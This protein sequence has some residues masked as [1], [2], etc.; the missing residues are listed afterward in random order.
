M[1]LLITGG[2]RQFPP[3]RNA[4]C[5]LRHHKKVNIDAVW[6]ID[7]GETAKYFG[8]NVAAIKETLGRVD[9]MISTLEVDELNA[10]EKIPNFMAQFVVRD[11]YQNNVI[12]DLTAGPKFITSLLYAAANFCRIEQ[13]YYFLL[14]GNK[15]NLPF[16]ELHES[17]YDYLS[18]A[19]FS[20]ESIEDLSRRSFID[21]I[22]Y[23]KDIDDL[24]NEYLVVAPNLAEM[25]EQSL[26]FAVQNYFR[27]DYKS[28]VRHVGTMLETWTARLHQFL[29]TQGVLSQ[30]PTQG[31]P[32]AQQNSWAYH[33]HMMKGF[34]A[35][36]Q[37]LRQGESLGTLD[38]S[39]VSDALRIAFITDLLELVRPFR[40]MASHKADTQYQLE[41]S[42]AKLMLDIGLTIVRKTG[43]TSTIAKGISS[44][45]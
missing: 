26:K 32:L 9:I 7:N 30:Y 4:L 10:S 6:L 43:A 24:I 29:N 17:D 44:V 14:K 19:P 41:K 16:E 1:T 12:V 23:L 15:Y 39:L 35:K 8:D 31:T 45:S 5:A 3:L 27:G 28:A 20:S 33:T 34:F 37:K 22:F 21:L 36:I 25:I 2:T 13:I 42:D 11:E 38:P 18:L 40:N